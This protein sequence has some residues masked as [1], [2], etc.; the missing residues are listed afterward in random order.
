MEKHVKIFTPNDRGRDFVVGDLH[1]CLDEFNTELERIKFD[2]ERDRMFSVGDLVDRGPNSEDCLN[3]LFEP[4]FHAVKGNHE[5]LWYY[6]HV[7]NPNQEILYTFMVNGGELLPEE[8]FAKYRE[9]VEAMPYMIEVEMKSGKRIGIIHAELESN[10]D[11]WERM[12]KIL[13]DAQYPDDDAIRMNGPIAA[14]VWGNDR[15]RKFRRQQDRK[16]VYKEIKGIDEIYVGHTIVPEPL[17]YQKINYIDCGAV[18]P[19]W[20]SKNKL[21]KYLKNGKL[22]NPRL[23]VKELY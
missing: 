17:T 16:A 6:S 22:P 3:L 23:I 11:D 5:I 13:I 14:L 2:K 9:T 1:G 8:I 12:K 15:I 7:N 10:L 4:W 19:Y 21:E 20:L 18:L